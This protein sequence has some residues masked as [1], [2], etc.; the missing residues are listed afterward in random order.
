MSGW[1][2]LIKAPF[3]GLGQARTPDMA[4]TRQEMK[5][6]CVRTAFGNGE[7]FT[8]RHGP[9]P[10]TPSPKTLA[11]TAR[12]LGEGEHDQQKTAHSVEGVCQEFWKATAQ[13]PCGHALLGEIRLSYGSP[14]T[15]E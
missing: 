14:A 1:L 11:K 2:K 6:H 3:A 5:R 15:A 8:G 13:R 4:S 10:L 9:L 7:R 12:V